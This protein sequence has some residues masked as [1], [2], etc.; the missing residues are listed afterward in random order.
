MSEP[1]TERH[2][3]PSDDWPVLRTPPTIPRRRPPIIGPLFK[4]VSVAV[5]LIAAGAVFWLL[6]ASM[7]GPT[8]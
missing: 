5:G 2:R 8:P 4:A 7:K 3:A 6:L 1:R